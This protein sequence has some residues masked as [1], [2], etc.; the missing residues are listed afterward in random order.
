MMDSAWDRPLQSLLGGEHFLAR[1][2]LY[3]DFD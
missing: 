1:I 3:H 2:K